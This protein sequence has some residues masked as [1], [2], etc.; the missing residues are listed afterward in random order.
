MTIWKFGCHWGGNRHSFYEFIRKEALVLGHSPSVQFEPGDLV[1]ITEGFTVR[2]I[3]KVE[4]H[5]RS[6]TNQ[7]EYAYV[8]KQYGIE[9]EPTTIIA[10]AEWH[11]LPVTFEYKH[12]PGSGRVHSPEIL[13]LTIDAWE[14]RERSVPLVIPRAVGEKHVKHEVFDQVFREFVEFIQ[15]R[16]GKQ[17]TTFSN[18]SYVGHE[19]GYKKVIYEQAKRELRIRD[20]TVGDI[21]TGKIQKL[22]TA[23]MV[24]VLKNDPE[25]DNNLIDWRKIDRFK[26]LVVNREIEQTLFSHFKNRSS[27]ASAFAEFLNAGLDYQS[28]AYLFFIKDSSQFLPIAQ[29]TFDF[30]IADKLQIDDFKTSRRASWEN[31]QIFLDLIRQTRR[32]LLSKDPATTLLDAHS[33]LWILGRQR[34]DWLDEKRREKPES[35]P[36]SAAKPVVIVDENR[37]DAE[38]THFLQY[39]LADQAER[40]IVAGK[41]LEHI[42][43]NQYKKKRVRA[44]D[45][46]WVVTIKRTG[47]FV[48]IG[49]LTVAG[50]VSLAEAQSM[51]TDEVFHR[52]QHIVADSQ[53]AELMQE[54]D[55]DDIADDLSFISAKHPKLT[56]VNG[57][58]D[59]RQIQS[60]RI[61]TP[62]SVKLLQSKWKSL[63]HEIAEIEA[64]DDVAEKAIRDSSLPEVEKQQ[65]IKARRGQ[66]RFRANLSKIEK[67]CRVTGIADT[68]FLIASHIKPWRDSTKA[69]KLDGN[70]GL[71]LSPH[72]DKLFDGGWISFSNEGKILLASKSLENLLTAWG[73]STGIR[74]GSFSKEQQTYLAYHRGLF[75]FDDI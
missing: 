36:K 70:N 64:A 4:E 38:Q 66:G 30:I 35:R 28:I 74:V 26:K 53:N 63:D 29:Q 50:L 5:Q 57:R 1:L 19:E 27:N 6:I 73:L 42:G 72:V 37:D 54:I 44:D 45:V 52:N 14:H 16:D 48:L 59:G 3:A 34:E 58:I 17:F 62:E 71:W 8:T 39:W 10:N 12:Q 21:G 11:E 75:G 32:F 23:S 51:F 13:A 61:L 67:G 25:R 69:E 15:L 7:P 33:F 46:F 60:I 40:D 20:W 56:R 2:A 43:S 55:I 18:S 22:V 47:H 41:P 65:L 49:R 24:H 68:R 31:Y 9:F